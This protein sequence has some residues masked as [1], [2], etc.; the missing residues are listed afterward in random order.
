VISLCE[1]TSKK[2][3]GVQVV[4]SCKIWFWL[5]FVTRLKWCIVLLRG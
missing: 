2:N 3:C 5:D 4:F 1:M